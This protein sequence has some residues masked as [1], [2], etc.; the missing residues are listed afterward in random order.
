MIHGPLAPHL[1]LLR[2]EI[3]V[4]T[5]TAEFKRPPAPICAQ[6]GRSADRRCS[7]KADV[8]CR[9][10]SQPLWGGEPVFAK[11]V[12]KFCIAKLLRTFCTGLS[13][14]LNQD[15]GQKHAAKSLLPQSDPTAGRE[16]ET[17][18]H[19]LYE[20]LRLI[21]KERLWFRLDRCR[22]DSVMIT[23]TVVGERLEID[24]F[25]DGHVEFSRFLGDEGIESDQT[26]LL[27]LIARHGRECDPP[28]G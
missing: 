22:D 16:R 9:R 23:V 21:E 17:L 24:V 3:C 8:A 12:P 19:P 2:A 7:F 28:K 18:S 13:Q 1:A 26:Q 5:I 20:V 15:R 4:A 6:G 27:E 10:S 14:H 11:S 25:E